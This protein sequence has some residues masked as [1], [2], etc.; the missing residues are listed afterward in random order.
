MKIQIAMPSGPL[1]VE[2]YGQGEWAVHRIP[3]SDQYWTVTHVPTGLAAGGVPLSRSQAGDF[4]ARL[5][6]E[7]PTLGFPHA[8]WT[9]EQ[10][11]AHVF[12]QK[13]IEKMRA[14]RDEVL[15]R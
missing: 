8:V 9:S 4:A 11:E 10:L 1:E 14:L 13:M 15:G 7:I 6:A 12:D 5:A 2:A 3:H